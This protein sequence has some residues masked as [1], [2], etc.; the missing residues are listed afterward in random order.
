[1]NMIVKYF[2]VQKMDECRNTTLHQILSDCH[3]GT[4]SKS[5]KKWLVSTCSL[6]SKQ[7]LGKTCNGNHVEAC[8]GYI[9]KH[10]VSRTNSRLY[11]F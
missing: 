9:Y 10:F 8:Q 2:L 5:K 3:L 4:F 6:I 1:M 11:D 7:E